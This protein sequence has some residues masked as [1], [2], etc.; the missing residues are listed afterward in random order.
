MSQT[1]EY[2]GYEREQTA[3]TKKTNNKTVVSHIYH[4]VGI[5]LAAMTVEESDRNIFCSGPTLGLA[6]VVAN[7]CPHRPQPFEKVKNGQAFP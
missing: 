7:T 1:Y 6:L 2:T 5:I 4:V 3:K